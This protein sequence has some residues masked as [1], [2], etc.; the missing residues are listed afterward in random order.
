MTTEV[1]KTETAVATKPTTLK[2]FLTS[3]TSLERISD[4]L[5]PGKDPKRLALQVSSLVAKTPALRE[6]SQV[7]ILQCLVQAA[8]LG[9]EFMLNQAHMVPYYNKNT[10]SKEA[11]MQIGY[12]GMLD[13]VYRSGKL[14]SLTVEVVYKGD[15]FKHG[16]SMKEGPF[17]EH[18]PAYKNATPDDITFV[19]AIAFLKDGGRVKVVMT[20]DEIDKVKNSSKAKGMKDSPWNQ[21][22]EEM[23]KK[24][25]IKRIS[26]NLP[27]QV[28][29]H[30]LVDALVHDDLRDQGRMFGEDAIETTAHEVPAEE[31]SLDTL[32]KKVGA[33]K[34]DEPDDGIVEQRTGKK[35]DSG[36]RRRADDETPEPDEEVEF[37]G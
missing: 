27:M 4:V 32:A 28:I 25:V 5:P 13:L 2:D 11:Q 6:C 30:T 18:E 22:Y 35:K 23:A 24:T 34:D 20:K 31:S 33:V 12:K 8:E 26:K 14:D 9:L 10:R 15:K 36:K 1:A 17:L 3:A 37:D 21:W 19:Y 16:T 7:S 29:D